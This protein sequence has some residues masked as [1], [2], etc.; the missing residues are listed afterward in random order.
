M[1]RPVSLLLAFLLV[2]LVVPLSALPVSAATSGT[3]GDCTWTLDGTK[4]TISGKGV[5]GDYDYSFD[6]LAPWGTYITSVVMEDG[7]TSIGEEAFYGCKK[8]T[9]VTIPDSVTSIGWGAFEGCTALTSV[10]IPNSVT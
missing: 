7:V 5:M 8:L 9:S 1:K 2:A 4:L 6:L 10:T 3:T